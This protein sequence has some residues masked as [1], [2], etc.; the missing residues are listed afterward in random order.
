MNRVAGVLYRDTLVEL[1]ELLMH[2]AN[3]VG[4]GAALD[5]LVS[6]SQGQLLTQHL[7]AAHA[8][9]GGSAFGR[10]L[11]QLRLAVGTERFNSNTRSIL[12]LRGCQGAEPQQSRS[13][14][15]FFMKKY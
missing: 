6:G 12:C 4:F 14:A 2:H 11:H 7:V 13:R 8:T 5:H 3:L 10:K 1:A 9:Q 15:F